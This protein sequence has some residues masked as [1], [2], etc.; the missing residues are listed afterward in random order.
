MDTSEQYIKMCAALP[1]E[2][3]EI[4]PFEP[5]CINDE[6]CRLP[7]L[8]QLQEILLSHT[9]KLPIHLHESFSMWLHLQT[10]QNH[11]WAFHFNTFEKMWLA[12]VM[13]EM[14][15]LIWTGEKWEEV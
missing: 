15:G 9:G 4:L 11:E 13:R 1:A 5:V 8:D 6:Q 3:F 14:Y 12:Y 7:R 2:L 10:K